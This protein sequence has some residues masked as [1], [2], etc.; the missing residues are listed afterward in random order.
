MRWF[1]GTSARVG[2]PAG[3]RI[4]PV[5]AAQLIGP[6]LACQTVIARAAGQHITAIAADQRIIAPTAGQAVIAKATDHDIIA[7]MHA[8]PQ[9]IAR[10]MIVEVEHSQVGKVKTL[11]LPV[12]FSDT[13]GGV[14]HGAPVLG[15]HTREI[16][17]EAGYSMDEVNVL[18]TEGAVAT[19]D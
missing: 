18:L 3:Q 15:E 17:L 13:P 19:P 11:G 14:R 4:A 7:Q 8:D 10:D 5:L 9:T 12:K 1:A 6:G 2:Q 16:L